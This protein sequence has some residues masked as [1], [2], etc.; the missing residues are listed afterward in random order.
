MSGATLHLLCAGAIKGLVK[1]LQPVLQ[2]RTGATLSARY[3]AVGAMKEALLAGAPCDLMIATDK[4]IDELIDSGALLASGRT[5][6]GC[7][8][9]GVAVS[10]QSTGAPRP[11]V[12]TPEALKATLLAADAIFFPDPL[13]ATAGIHFTNVMRQLGIHD[14]LADRF[15][16]FENGATSMRELAAA[17]TGASI[18]CT[19]VSEILYTDGVELLACLPAPFELVTVYTA[20]VGSA[21]AD[22]TLA[23]QFVAMLSGHRNGTHCTSQGVSSPE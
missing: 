11:D 4:M 23:A 3:G 16:T 8:H 14:Q 6:I 10:G 15:R 5:P 22:P 7:V 21:A 9:S 19:Q 1:A 2:E 20:A 18:G 17:G 13:R 12:S